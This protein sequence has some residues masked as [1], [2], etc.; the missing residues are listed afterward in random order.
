MGNTESPLSYSPF[1][2]LFLNLACV[3]GTC[4][5]LL[6]SHQLA[7]LQPTVGGPRTQG[8]CS[9]CCVFITQ[10]W[11]WPRGALGN[12]LWSPNGTNEVKVVLGERSNTFPVDFFNTHYRECLLAIG[13]SALCLPTTALTTAPEEGTS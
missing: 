8:F 1:P 2:I 5:T 4:P 3:K 6:C 7:I 13:L 11:A 12:S 10:H 9:K